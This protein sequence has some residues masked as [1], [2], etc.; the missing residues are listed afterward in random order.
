MYRWRGWN[1]KQAKIIFILMSFKGNIFCLLLLKR[2][3]IIISFSSSFMSTLTTT[4]NFK[5]HESGVA[6]ENVPFNISSFLSFFL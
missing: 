1:E 5:Q 3:K 4:V 6:D 2:R